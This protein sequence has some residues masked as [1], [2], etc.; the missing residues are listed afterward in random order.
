MDTPEKDRN[1]DDEMLSAADHYPIVSDSAQT[2]HNSSPVSLASLASLSPNSHRPPVLAIR[3]IIKR[4]RRLSAA[5]QNCLQRVFDAC[6]KPSAAI[7]DRLADRLGMTKR[8]IQIWFQNRRAKQKRDQ[9][10]AKQ[11]PLLFKATTASTAVSDEQP[12][13]EPPFDE[14]QLESLLL[15]CQSYVKE[16]PDD[17]LSPA[18]PFAGEDADAML[19]IIDPAILEANITV[20]E[21]QQQFAGGAPSDLFELYLTI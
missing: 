13:E 9:Q 5:E 15:D 16:A 20:L 11:P 6:P 2:D 21:Q 19:P 3:N 8:C 7:R 12:P 1:A 14:R 4:R 17:W 10:D 18:K